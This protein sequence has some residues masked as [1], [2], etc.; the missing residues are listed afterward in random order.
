MSLAWWAWGLTSLWYL[1]RGNLLLGLAT[2]A[3]NGVLILAAHQVPGMAASYGL[4]SWQAGLGVFVVG[5]VIQFVGHYFEGRKPAFADDITGLL[6]GPMFVVGE[7][8]MALGLLAQLR[9]A[10]ERQAGPT[11]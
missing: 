9:L 1:S 11:H 10:V 7:V 5:W 3:V 8:L 6:V 2:T 4:P